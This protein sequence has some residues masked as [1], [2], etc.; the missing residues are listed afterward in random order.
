MVG[1]IGDTQ[2]NLCQVT[3]PRTAATSAP[4]PMADHYQPMPLQET[5]TQIDLAQ[6][7]VCVVFRFPGDSQ[8]PWPDPLDGVP[9]VGLGPLQ[10]C[11]SFFGIIVLQFVG[12]QPNRALL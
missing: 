12:H 1:T 10:L 7:S 8:S 2:D 5:L 6:S 11:E 4:F 3:S 9:H